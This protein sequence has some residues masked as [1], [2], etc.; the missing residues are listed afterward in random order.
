MADP[1]RFRGKVVLITGAS[2]GIGEG[3]ALRFAAEGADVVLA[4]NEERVHAVAT[5][6]AHLG[7]R[8]L[9]LV[10]DVT[11][12]LQVQALFAQA[13]ETFGRVD[14]SVH[15][16]GV[17]TIARLSELTE[18]E[19]DRVL[20]VNTKGVFLCCQAA[21]EQMVPQGY[22]R[23]INLGS[24]QSRQGSAYSP[25]YAASKFGVI[26]LTQSLAK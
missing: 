6:V 24:G 21:A 7:V 23:I 20:D 9:S 4:A 15:S 19:W 26:G 16:A 25:H 11:G 10:V 12:K 17:I 18:E 22:G 2:R 3:I 8:A 14:V 5:E 1:G 13:V